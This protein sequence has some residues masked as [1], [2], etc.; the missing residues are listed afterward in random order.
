[1]HLFGRG[2]PMVPAVKA[3][4]LTKRYGDF[5]AVN[6]LDLEIRPGECFGFLG[7]NGAGKST[8]MKMIYGRT[9]ITSGELQVLGLDTKTAMRTIKSR[10]GVIPQEDSL[11]PDF[12]VLENLLVYGRYFGLKGAPAR[13]R[14]EELLA[15]VQLTE[16]AKTNVEALSGGMKRR[17]V[18]ARALMNR[19]ELLILDEP[20]TGLDPQARH[21]VWS[22]MRTLKAQGVTLLLTTH[23]MDEAAQLCDRLV[24]VD[25]GQVLALGT[26]QELMAQHAGAWALELRVAPEQH[27]TVLQRAERVATAHEAI[28]DLLVIYLPGQAEA[29]GLTHELRSTGVPLQGYQAR[30][31]TL[32]DVFLRL[33]GRSLQEG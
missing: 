16:K 30:P 28:G 15:F 29:E 12:S 22:R 32:E 4:Q 1:E 10:I 18:I 8:T 19:P 31:T 7:P 24:I 6:N 2:E 27:A 14:A 21:L 17:L 25:K 11:D 33:A 3:T 9:P 23:Y 26:P 5:T 13:Q 20:S